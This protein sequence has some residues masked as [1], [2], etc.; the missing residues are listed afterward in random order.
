MNAVPV[1]ADAAPVQ[2]RDSAE[3][4]ISMSDFELEATRRDL[5]TNLGLMRPGNG[6]YTPSQRL[7]NA[8]NGEIARRIA[9]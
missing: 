2:E 3:H 9:M 4:M 6:M 1:D 5:V 8:V 7:L